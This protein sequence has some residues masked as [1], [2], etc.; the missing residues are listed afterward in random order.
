MCRTFDVRNIKMQTDLAFSQLTTIGCGGKIDLVVFPDTISKLVFVAKF[1]RRHK[2][3]HCFLGRGSNVL[4]SDERYCGVV[5]VTTKVQGIAF[6]GNCAE[7]CCGTSAAALCAELVKKGLHGGEFLGCLPATVGGVV[8]CN[9]GCFGQ[10]AQNV[11]QSVVAL[12]KGKIVRLDNKQ[13]AFGKRNS[14]F[15]DGNVLVLQVVMR[16]EKLTPSKVQQI[17]CDMRQKK[18]QTQPLGQRSAGCVLYAEGVAVSKLTDLAGLKGFKIGGAQVSEKH[19][20]F[21]I[22]LDKATSKDIYLLVRHVQNV[23][24]EKFGVKSV[25]EVSFINF[26]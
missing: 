5:V 2:I 22:N 14:I 16:F 26:N 17:V 15:K 8:A 4:A 24:Q 13:C 21:V 12:R 11:V 1:L 23:V 19:A 3:K 18:Q 7:V 20:G 10:S 9:A 6:W 25:A